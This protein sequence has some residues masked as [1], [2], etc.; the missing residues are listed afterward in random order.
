MNTLARKTPFKILA[1]CV[2]VFVAITGEKTA[3]PKFVFQP[4]LLQLTGN[5]RKEGYCDIVFNSRVTISN[6]INQIIY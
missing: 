2:F 5:I 1:L 4:V 3:E 6:S